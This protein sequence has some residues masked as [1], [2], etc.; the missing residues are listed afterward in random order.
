MVS[1]QYNVPKQLHIQVNPNAQVQLQVLHQ[2]PLVSKQETTTSQTSP[3][4]QELPKNRLSQVKTEDHKD[5]K[6]EEEEKQKPDAT[7]SFDTPLPMSIIAAEG[8]VVAETDVEDDKDD[9]ENENIP[10]EVV[11]EEVRDSDLQVHEEVVLAVHS[12]HEMSDQMEIDSGPYFHPPRPPRRVSLLEYKERMKGKKKYPSDEPQQGDSEKPSEKES[13]VMSPLNEGVKDNIVPQPSKLHDIQ[14]AIMAVKKSPAIKDASGHV[15]V[16]VASHFLRSV[17]DTKMA[18]NNFKDSLKQSSE[19]QITKKAT[20]TPNNPVI[21]QGHEPSSIKWPTIDSDE[22]REENQESSRVIS[23]EVSVEIESENTKEKIDVKKTVNNEPMEVVEKELQVKNSTSVCEQKDEEE[24]KKLQENKESK[25]KEEM[26]KKRE[27]EKEREWAKRL[28]ELEREWKKKK[29]R[30]RIKEEKEKQRIKEERERERIR[31]GREKERLKEEKEKNR[32]KEVRER[33]MARKAAKPVESWK[34]SNFPSNQKRFNIPIRHGPTFHP[35]P[36]P[37]PIPAPVIPPP[38]PP[39]PQPFI[40]FPHTP[41]HQPPPAPFVPPHPRPPPLPQP[42]VWSMFGNL[43]VQHNLFPAEEPP[44]PPPRSPSP[45]L[46]SNRF[47]PPRRKSPRRSPPLHRSSPPPHIDPPRPRSTSPTV[48]PHHRISPEPASFPIRRKSGSPSPVS[49]PWPLEPKPRQ[50]DAKQ[51]R[52]ISE[53]VKRTTVKK[54]DVS[55]QAVPPRMVSEGTQ[56]GTGFRLCS[57]AVQVKARTY[58]VATLTDCK[59]EIQ[60]R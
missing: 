11:E 18:D 34:P 60:D 27:Q 12:D 51:F 53:L 20:N 32:M 50:L 52:V 30:E 6:S 10:D 39:P 29:E 40:G 57:T 48:S 28:E 44:P 24:D 15:A 56:D 25:Q 54:C 49:K 1:L 9:G 46:P 3:I 45:P 21:Q 13:C 36:R 19:Q 59:P 47:S 35:R 2:A 5:E 8:M 14:Q 31:E 4:E 22:S 58:S 43:F 38:Q 26:E 41:F 7:Q 37:I 23:S 42:D 33:K 17:I 55:V 16:A